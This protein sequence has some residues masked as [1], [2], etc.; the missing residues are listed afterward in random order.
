MHCLHLCTHRTTQSLRKAGAYQNRRRMFIWKESGS[1]QCSAQTI[2][3]TFQGFLQRDR[4]IWDFF[5]Y[6]WDCMQKNK[7]IVSLAFWT[8]KRY[9]FQLHKILAPKLF[10]IFFLSNVSENLDWFVGYIKT[11]NQLNITWWPRCHWYNFQIFSIFASCHELFDLWMLSRIFPTLFVPSREFYWCVVLV[12]SPG[13][14]LTVCFVLANSFFSPSLFFS[15]IFLYFFFH[16][17]NTKL[18]I[19]QTQVFQRNTYY[20]GCHGTRIK[21]SRAFNP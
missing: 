17:T 1:K 16:R 18:L 20:Y 14:L 8:I 10:N 6:S 7:F 2:L 11:K 5:G 21:T 12:R 15:S 9:L 3:L 19:E 4:I 13:C